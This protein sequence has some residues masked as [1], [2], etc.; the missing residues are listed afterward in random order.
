[1]SA[2]L[3]VHGHSHDEGRTMRYDG[4]RATLRGRFGRRQ[5]LTV[6]S[7][8][9]GEVEEVPIPPVTSGH[10]GGDAG[11]IESFLDSIEHGKPPATSASESIESHLLAFLAEEARLEGTVIEVASRRR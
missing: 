11:I 6:H 3:T 10:G 5:E 9:S 8:A 2:G 1:A 7:H 4:T